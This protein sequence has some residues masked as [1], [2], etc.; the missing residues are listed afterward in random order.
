VL[1]ALERDLVGPFP[2]KRKVA[3]IASLLLVDRARNKL[4][5][6]AP[7]PNLHMCFTGP[8]GTGKTTMALRMAGWTAYRTAF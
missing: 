6:T 4:G 7:R 1:A 3:E 2:V 5:L 8:P